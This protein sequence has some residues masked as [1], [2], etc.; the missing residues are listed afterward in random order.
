[1]GETLPAGTDDYVEW[2]S[3]QLDLL[4]NALDRP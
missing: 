2:I 3:G 4:T 1:V